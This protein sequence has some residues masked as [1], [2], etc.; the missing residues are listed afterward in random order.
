[1]SE[2][3]QFIPEITL[4]INKLPSRGLAYPEGARLKYLTYTF[5]EVQEASTSNWDIVDSVKLALKG[6]ICEGFDKYQLTV[7]DVFYIGILRKVSSMNELKFEMPYIC[8]GCMKR[9]KGVF[10]QNDIEFRDIDEAVK[11]LP[12]KAEI[13]GKQLDFSPMTVKEFLDIQSG[14]YANIIGKKDEMNKMAIYATMI[15]NL[16][17]KEAYELLITNRN[18]DDNEVLEEIDRLLLHDMKPLITTCQEEVIDMDGNKS[19]CGFENAL[20]LEGREALLRPFREG[21]RPVRDRIWLGD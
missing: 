17:F 11:K 9:T 16:P 12:I 21:K 5:G 14:R 7:L 20:K 8:R 13:G 1:M 6:I 15:K 3:K 19:K 10:T 2:E 18:N 4:D